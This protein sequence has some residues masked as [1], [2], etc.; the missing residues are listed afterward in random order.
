VTIDEVREKI[1]RG[2]Y[3]APYPSMQGQPTP[4]VKD[5]RKLWEV[6]EGARR[7]QFQTDALTAVGLA[8]HPK[9]DKIFW[10]AWDRGH[11]SGYEEVLS[12]LV[13]L[14]ELFV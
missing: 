11:S 7:S 8:S 4:L 1:E 13:N 3:E 5:A 12:V 9:A 6:E 10:Y 2:G 14:A